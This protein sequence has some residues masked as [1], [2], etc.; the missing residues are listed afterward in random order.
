MGFP[1]WNDEPIR[2]KIRVREDHPTEA[3][4]VI[5]DNPAV[6]CSPVMLCGSAK[7]VID[8]MTDILDD[9]MKNSYLDPA[10]PDVASMLSEVAYYSNARR[11]FV[12]AHQLSRFTTNDMSFLTMGINSCMLALGFSGRIHNTHYAADATAVKALG[13]TGAEGAIE[14][15][16]K[17]HKLQTVSDTRMGMFDLKRKRAK[18]AR[19]MQMHPPLEAR[20][21]RVVE[22]AADMGV[23]E[24]D[25][26]RAAGATL[27]APGS[28]RKVDL[29]GVDTVEELFAMYPKC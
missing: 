27:W 5:G 18:L 25:L 3:F 6:G 23:A 17:L 1:T 12:I 11:Q 19:W 26:V 16:A 9:S 8:C 20:A 7:S 22:L 29:A 4:P 28:V 2:L 10:D 21:R 13:R 15:F 14:H 24:A